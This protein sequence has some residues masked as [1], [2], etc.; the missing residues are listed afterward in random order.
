MIKVQSASRQQFRPRSDKPIVLDWSVMI[1]TQEQRC[2][3]FFRDQQADS[4]QG[5]RYYQVETHVEKMLTGDYTMIDFQG[6]K[7]DEFFL[8]ERKSFADIVGSIDVHDDRRIRFEEEH[9]RMQVVKNNGGFA[10]VVIEGHP[11]M[12][13]RVPGFSSRRLYSTW[14]S[15]QSQYDIEWIWAGD[16]QMAEWMSFQLMIR[17]MR[18]WKRKKLNMLVSS[19]T[20]R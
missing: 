20:S 13:S 17:G 11:A 1:D 6:Q 9:Q 18:A 10:Y 4:K 19:R 5:H 2:G 16:A 12:Q 7:L 15:W 8:I 3:W 14:R